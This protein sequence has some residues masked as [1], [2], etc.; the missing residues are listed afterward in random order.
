MASEPVHE[1]GC[2]CGRVRWRASGRARRAVHCHCEMCRRTSG[3]AFATAAAFPAADVSWVKGEP[4]LYRSSDEASRGF[5][6]RCG[7]WLSWHT[8]DGVVWL[9]VGTFDAPHAIEPELHAWAEAQLPWTERL[10][11]GLP[12]HPRSPTLTG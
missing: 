8:E 6:A 9:T 4:T 2:L 3:A 11:D 5:C 1:G 12:R 7:S 10:D